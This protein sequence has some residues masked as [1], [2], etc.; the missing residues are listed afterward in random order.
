MIPQP[1]ESDLLRLLRSVSPAVVIPASMLLA[2]AVLLLA[3]CMV[4]GV[5]FRWWMLT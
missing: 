2:G 5:L 3:A 4:G 1:T